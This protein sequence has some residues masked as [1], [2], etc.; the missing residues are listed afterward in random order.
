[1]VMTAGWF[2]KFMAL[3]YPHWLIGGGLSYHVSEANSFFC[4][5]LYLFYHTVDGCMM[6][7]I[8]DIFGGRKTVDGCDI[9]QQLVDGK[10]PMMLFGFQPLKMGQEFAT[11]HKSWVV[12]CV[13]KWVSKMVLCVMHNETINH[14]ILIRAHNYKTNPFDPYGTH[15][16]ITICLYGYHGASSQ[17]EGH[18]LF[19][20][21]V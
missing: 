1:M 11:I 14:W 10:H 20:N 17:W 21:G 6:G 12:E 16:N 18:P 15:G 19:L 9:L 7:Y 2:K 13:L 5:G 4:S 8:M 3:F